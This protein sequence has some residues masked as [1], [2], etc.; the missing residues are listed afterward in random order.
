MEEQLINGINILLSPFHPS[1]TAQF[2][3]NGYVV[4]EFEMDGEKMV[5]TLAKDEEH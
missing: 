4:W 1:T 3:N 5:V 2:A